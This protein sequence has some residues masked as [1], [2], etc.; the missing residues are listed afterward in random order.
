MGIRPHHLLLA[1]LLAAPAWAADS[2]PPAVEDV[3]E[4]AAANGVPRSTLEAKAREGV[5]KGVPEPRLIGALQQL[6]GDLAE[7]RALLPAEASSDA[8]GSAGA[9]LREGASAAAVRKVG[10]VP[11]RLRPSALQALA[12]LLAIGFLESEA[13]GLIE[14]ATNAPQPQVALTG[15]AS[16]GAA[17]TG[18]GVPSHE[19]ADSLLDAVVAGASPL[20]TLPVTPPTGSGAPG[21]IPGIPPRGGNR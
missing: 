12:D 21:N 8:V 3:I 7:A 4:A 13:V 10:A 14:A 20:T 2:L 1:L 16:A 17:L 18:A 6:V 15:L 9:A 5:A 11:P 19:A